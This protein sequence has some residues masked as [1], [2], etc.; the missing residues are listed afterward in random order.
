M[1]DS[2]SLLKDR[3]KQFAL[4]VINLVE[5]LPSKRTGAVIGHFP[6]L[7]SARSDKV[8]FVTEK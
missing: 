8:E 5:S 6:Q 4:R 3:T 2:D 7:R 1:A